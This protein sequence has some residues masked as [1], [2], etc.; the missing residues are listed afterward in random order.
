M[1]FPE[2]GLITSISFRDALIDLFYAHGSDNIYADSANHM[3]TFIPEILNRIQ[4][5]L[6]KIFHFRYYI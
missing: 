5:I 6:T 2:S 3:T 4:E 1:D